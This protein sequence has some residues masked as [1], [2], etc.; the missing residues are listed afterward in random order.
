[1]RRIDGPNW[2]DCIVCASHARRLHV[3]IEKLCLHLSLSSKLPASCHLH[4]RSNGDHAEMV[5]KTKL[6]STNNYK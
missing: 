3:K 6:H 4:S 2:P 5:R 1:M